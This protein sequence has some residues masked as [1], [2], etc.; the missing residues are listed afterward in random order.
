[1]VT[2]IHCEGHNALKLLTRYAVEMECVVHPAKGFI[3]GTRTMEQTPS[4]IPSTCLMNGKI[5]LYLYA[6]REY[7]LGYSGTR[8]DLKGM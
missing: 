2:A 7:P 5:G 1:M 6:Q 3:V 4:T 8:Q